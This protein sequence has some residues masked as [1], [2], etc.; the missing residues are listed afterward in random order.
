MI[1][2]FAYALYVYLFRATGLSFGA[3]DFKFGG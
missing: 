1:K 3:I 2:A